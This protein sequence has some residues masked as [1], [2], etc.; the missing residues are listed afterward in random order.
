MLK[1]TNCPLC[2]KLVKFNIQKE[3]VDHSGRYPAPV[4]LKHNDPK[5]GQWI[6]VYFDSQ[7]RVSLTFKG[8]EEVAKKWKF[9]KELTSLEN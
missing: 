8:K 5:C 7:M 2:S 1:V 3:D 9:V 6:T 4:Y